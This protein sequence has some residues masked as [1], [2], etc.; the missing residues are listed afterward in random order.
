MFHLGDRL[1]QLAG[2]AVFGHVLWRQPGPAHQDTTGSGEQSQNIAEHVICRRGAGKGATGAGVARQELC[3][4]FY[5]TGT[6]QQD[7]GE[8]KRNRTRDW[9]RWSERSR[10]CEDNA[11]GAAEMTGRIK[12][13]EKKMNIYEY[14]LCK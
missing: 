2:V 12:P 11:T 14:S 13:E 6:V 9:N 3:N 1:Q 8:R 5:A 7:I 10:C 4:R